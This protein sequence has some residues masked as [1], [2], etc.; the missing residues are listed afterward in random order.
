MIR[1]LSPPLRD[2]HYYSHLGGGVYFHPNCGRG[3]ACRRY[4]FLS[5]LRSRILRWT[6]I[7]IKFDFWVSVLGVPLTRKIGFLLASLHLPWLGRSRCTWTMGVRWAL[8]GPDRRAYIYNG[9]AQRISICPGGG[10][11]KPPSPRGTRSPFPVP[12]HRLAELGS[13]GGVTPVGNP[14]AVLPQQLKDCTC[15]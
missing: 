1:Y 2:S 8:L 4:D 14:L 13:W 10:H 15:R 5:A 6:L 12:L 11:T 7:L 9:D 3:V